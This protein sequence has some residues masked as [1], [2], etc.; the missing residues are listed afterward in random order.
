MNAMAARMRLPVI[1][2]LKQTLKMALAA[3]HVGQAPMLVVRERY[4]TRLLLHAF[5][6]PIH[7]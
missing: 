4:G 2:I 5:R 7:A 1:T 6:T 3:F